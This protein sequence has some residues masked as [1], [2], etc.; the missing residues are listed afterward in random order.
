MSSDIS[1]RTRLEWRRRYAGPV[2]LSEGFRPMFLLAGLWGVLSVPLWLGVWTGAIPYSGLLDPAAWHIHEMMFGYVGA[3]LGGFVLT[4]VP[5]WTGRLP[6]RGVPLALLALTWIAGR[7]AVWWSGEIGPVPAAVADIAFLGA[8]AALVGNEIVVGR[9]WRNLPVLAGLAA[10]VAANALFHVSAAGAAD[11]GDAATRLSI[12]AIALLL[13]LLGGRLVPSFTRNWFAKQAGP[14]IAAPM[15]RFD[16]AA[17]AAAALALAAWAAAGPS[18]V[19]GVLLSVAGA[20]NLLRL[21]RWRGWNTIAEPLVTVLH[22]GYLWLALG[23]CLLGLSMLSD[24]A[25]EP[26]ALHVLSIGAFGTMTL[27]VMTRAVLGH[28]GRALHAGPWTTAVYGLATLAVFARAAFEIVPDTIL[29]WASR[30]LL[31][32][33]FRLI[34]NGLRADAV[35]PAQGVTP[36]GLEQAGRDR[37]N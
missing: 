14:R 32:A 21:A 30:R 19:C 22:V 2:F 8:L 16:R 28:T 12:A 23:L 27:A 35:T 33:R 15:G 3:A 17:L 11:L 34:H 25:P 29:L 1:N 4:A 10:V 20:L 37:S 13:A 36:V 6:V 26:L 5:N 18:V 24:R 31:V 7:A 9:N